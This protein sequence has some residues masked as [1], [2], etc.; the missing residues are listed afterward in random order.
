MIYTL[1]RANIVLKGDN[2]EITVIPKKDP[3][4]IDTKTGKIIKLKVAAYARVS[5]DLEDQKNSFELQKEEFETRIKENPEW[6]FV[7]MYAD[8]GI[9]GTQIKHRV[10]FQKMIADAKEHKIDLIL[11]KSISRF[12]RNTVDLLKTVRELVSIGVGVFFEKENILTTK[13]NVDLVLTMYASLAESESRSISDNVK[14]GV[15]KR[16]SKNERKVPVNRMVGY[17]QDSKGNWYINEDAALIQNI[18]CY[19]MQGYTY[20]QIA[21]KI[22][23]ED[24]N[25][26]R[27]WDVARIH[28][29]LHNEKYKGTVV[30]QKTVVIDVL[31][32]KQ[33][34]NDGIEPKYIVSGHHPGI[35][36]EEDFDYVQMILNSNERNFGE[37]T[38]SRISEFSKLV[39]CEKCGRNL[40]RIK[41][42][43][44]NEYYLTC[45]NKLKSTSDYIKCDASVIPYSLLQKAS[46]DII[47][48]VKNEPDVSL[49]FTIGMVS[50]F[51]K[52]D[53]VKEIHE[54][55]L[56]IAE[57]DRSI[58][59]LV[60]QQ[61]NQTTI[62]EYEVKFN[63]L[64]AKRNLLVEEHKKISKLAKNNYELQRKL[65]QITEFLK[66]DDIRDV[67]DIDVFIAKILH[68]E[69]G[70][71]R[72]G[73]KGDGFER[74]NKEE[75]M[76][77]LKNNEPIYSSF[78]TNQLGSINYD[79][80][81]I[82]G[83]KN[84]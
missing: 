51:S 33:V 80:V 47:S 54:I 42:A 56:K 16:M 34:K 50:E 35:I 15:R 21:E 60:K 79:M 81:I 29:I 17:S 64:K 20:R 2:M 13:D 36:N 62:D 76:E 6:E 32:H 5:T 23:A 9:S 11:T 70:S 44:N 22:K 40:T 66:N 12:A 14:W 58:N 24:T 38:T 18:F 74:L 25:K 8:R 65:T 1:K 63:A 72:F 82:G 7:K 73:I 27:K 52:K 41:Y 46:N 75:I 49:G 71:L 55:E 53:F 67:A 19:F 57:I 3:V 39:I 4:K 77:Q 43:H 84:V 78:V 68:R 61:I 48:R 31:T 37:Y 59:E 26:E 69:N 30:H 83:N 45:K 28:R 10:Q